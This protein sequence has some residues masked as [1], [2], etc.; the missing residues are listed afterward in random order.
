MTRYDIIQ[1]FINER[2]FKSFLEIGTFNGD[3]FKHITI[4]KKESVDPDP[5][6]KATHIMTSDEYF[7]NSQ[8]K[9][10]IIFID[11]LHE[12]TQVYR[13]ICNSLE[14]LNPNGVIVMHDCMPKNEKMQLWD[15]KSHQ[16]EEWTGDTWKAYYKV[17]KELPYLVYVV[18]TDYGCGVIDTS[19]SREIEINN[20]D[21]DNLKYTDYLYY[22]STSQY[23]IKSV[24]EFTNG[25]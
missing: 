19:K 21:M 13:D 4:D 17:Y 6:C 20:I 7:K 5:N 22:T 15:N 10:D 1:K 2:Q 23:R 24:G 25:K 8:D 16:Y 12:H 9:W 18:D 14:H 11:G 3:T